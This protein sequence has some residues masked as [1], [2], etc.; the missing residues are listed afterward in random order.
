MRVLIV[1]TYI[2]FF[3]NFVFIFNT[4]FRIIYCKKIEDYQSC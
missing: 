4:N 1:K 3:S 2:Y